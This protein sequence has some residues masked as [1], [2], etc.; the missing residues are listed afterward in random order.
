MNSG[1]LVPFGT[2]VSM[3]SFSKVVAPILSQIRHFYVD[4]IRTMRDYFMG[5]DGCE[6]GGG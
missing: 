6:V 2:S 3:S 5:D 1:R 4:L